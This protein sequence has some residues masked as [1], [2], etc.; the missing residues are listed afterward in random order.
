MGV[1]ISMFKWRHFLVLADR[2][3]KNAF[4]LDAGK[5]KNLDLL[6]HVDLQNDTWCAPR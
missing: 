2:L 6:L 4:D 5:K 3:K 1:H